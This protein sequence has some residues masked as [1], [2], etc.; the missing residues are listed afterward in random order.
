MTGTN[1]MTGT[2]GVTG[3]ACCCFASEP[4]TAFPAETPLGMAYVPFQRWQYVY[5]PQ[6]GIERGTIF[7]ALDKPFIGER[8]V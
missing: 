8:T 6:V 4:T 2:T 3:T 5:D 1:G 7:E